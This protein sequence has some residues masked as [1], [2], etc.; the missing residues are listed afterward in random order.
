MNRN[1]L[2]SELA[3]LLNFTEDTADQDF[4]SNRLNKALDR[5][6][7]LEVERAKLQ[8]SYKYFHQT[9]SATWAASSQTYALVDPFKDKAIIDIYDVTS[10]EP[11]FPLV[12]AAHM[13]QGGNAFWKD[14]NTLQ[15]T[16]VGG[17]SDARTLRV[18]YEAT[19]ETLMSDES[20]PELVP[21]QFHYLLVWTASIL[22]REA[23][24]EEIPR[25]WMHEREEL[26]MD[27]YKHI[28][29]GRPTSHVPTIVRD[30]VQDDSVFY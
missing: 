29:R 15:W 14:R 5:A 24:D 23:G 9:A 19:A 8:G 27:F 16:G 22:L 25:S 26:R 7:N 30:P 20:I 13:N 4:T 6:Y 1:D 17:P 18:F 12:V 3:F 21:P 11:G 2:R 28:S 10:G